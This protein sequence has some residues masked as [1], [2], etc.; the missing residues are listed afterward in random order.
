MRLPWYAIPGAKCEVQSWGW[1]FRLP[2]GCFLLVCPWGGISYVWCGYTFSWLESRLS[3]S[4][5]SSLLS[6]SCTL[7]HPH[8]H[9]TNIHTVH[10]P[11][12]LNKALFQIFSR[13]AI[14]WWTN[15]D[16]V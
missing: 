13:M 5:P 15:Q 4:L 1:K 6:L 11:T 10:L 9:Y 7:M 12:L 14:V 2:E 8:M 16:M 3:L